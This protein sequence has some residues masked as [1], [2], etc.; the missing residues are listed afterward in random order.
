MILH[1]LRMRKIPSMQQA[2]ASTAIRKPGIDSLSSRQSL[3]CVTT[4]R[5]IEG[6]EEL[7]RHGAWVTEAIVTV[8]LSVVA[9]RVSCNVFVY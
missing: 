5:R 7:P 4:P 2:N 9:F 6:L 3:G 8:S 1:L